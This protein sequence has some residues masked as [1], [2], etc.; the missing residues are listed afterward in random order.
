MLD[1]LSKGMDWRE[2]PSSR[3]KAEKSKLK[4]ARAL[5]GLRGKDSGPFKNVEGWKLELTPLLLS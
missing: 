1:V 5:E 3:R 2:G 4:E